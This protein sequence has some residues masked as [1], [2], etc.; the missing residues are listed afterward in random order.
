MINIDQERRPGRF[1]RGH[2]RKRRRQVIKP[3]TSIAVIVFSVVSLAHLLRLIFGWEITINGI[4]VPLWVSVPGFIV[5]G[6]LAVMLLRE[7]HTSK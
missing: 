7:S 3:F 6:A 4:I 5:A 1:G 2:F